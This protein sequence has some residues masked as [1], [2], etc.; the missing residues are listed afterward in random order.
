MKDKIQHW[1]LKAMI[2]LFVVEMVL[3]LAAEI[4]RSISSIHLIVAGMVISIA[5]Y[6]IRERRVGREKRPRGG[7]GGERTPVMPRTNL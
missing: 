5:A 7:S 2:V 3:S 1:L 4:L 6:L